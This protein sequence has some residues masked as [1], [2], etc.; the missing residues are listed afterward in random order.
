MYHKYLFRYLTQKYDKLREGN[1]F[2]RVCHFFRE[3]GVPIVHGPSSGR[4]CTGPRPP[5]S[6]TYLSKVILQFSYCRKL[7][8][9]SPLPVC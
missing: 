7:S 8:K 5:P 2:S 9:I 3:G 6:A 1:V 4:S